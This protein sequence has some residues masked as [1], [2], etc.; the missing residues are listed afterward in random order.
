VKKIVLAGMTAM[1]LAGGAAIAQT[2]V[3]DPDQRTVIREYV[4]KEKVKPV[5]IK[6]RITV[7]STLPA[8][9]VLTPVPE[10]WGASVKPYRYVYWDNRVVLVDPPSRRVVHIVE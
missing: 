6:E 8:D 3:I 9:V 1:I 10:P 4:V 7:G 2:V 5:T